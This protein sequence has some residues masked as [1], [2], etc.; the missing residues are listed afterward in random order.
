MTNKKV[1][2]DDVDVSNC[3]YYVENNFPKGSFA[4][5]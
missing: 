1:I 2:I 5:W 4:A 3:K